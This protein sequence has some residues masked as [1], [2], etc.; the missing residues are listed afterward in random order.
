M[1]PLTTRLLLTYLLL[2]VQLTLAPYSAAELP[3][4]AA[5]STPSATV[6]IAVY[7]GGLPHVG[8]GDN[9]I[10]FGMVP[11]LLQPMWRQLNI[12]PTYID[13]PFPRLLAA[14]AERQVD[15]AIIPATTSTLLNQAEDIRC[16]EPPLLHMSYSLFSRKDGGVTNSP[17][18]GL[19]HPGRDKDLAMR[20]QESG[21]ATYS[22]HYLKSI[23]AMFKSLASDRLDF[24]MSTD[25]AAEFW[26]AQ[27]G[28]QFQSI[29]QFG[30]TMIYVCYITDKGNIN[31]KLEQAYQKMLEQT[32]LNQIK[33][34]YMVPDYKF[35]PVL[36]NDGSPK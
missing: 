36:K 33:A 25:L 34:T 17:R 26:S 20:M 28:T 16:M 14:L 35:D 23:G 10:I 11:D 19:L 5:A 8:H 4:P 29:H 30:A 2:G 1:P 12:E 13:F 22:R 3:A 24:V 9:G 6:R 21:Y 32:D 18:V 27:L 7:P 15:I 31:Y